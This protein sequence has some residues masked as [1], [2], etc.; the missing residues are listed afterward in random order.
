MTFAGA[1]QVFPF[2]AAAPTSASEG[3]S[4]G[5]W[6]LAYDPDDVKPGWI[7]LVL[8]L[9]L[10]VAT[11]LLWR[12]LNTQLRRI[13]MPPRGT[14]PADDLRGSDRGTNDDVDDPPDVP[15]ANP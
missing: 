15:N 5:G 9:V 13:Q 11:Y 14:R 6:L 8:V 4:I 3:N 12:S 1:A 7:A 2:A 10:A